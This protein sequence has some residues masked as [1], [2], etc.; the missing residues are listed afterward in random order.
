MGL[1]IP[2]ESSLELDFVYLLETD[3]RVTFFQAQPVR[4]DLWIDG[5]LRHHFPDFLIET[6]CFRTLAE[7]KPEKRASQDAYI[8]CFEASADKLQ[9]ED[10]Q[11]RVF[12]EEWICREPALT[13]AQLICR[14]ASD[15]IDPAHEL[16]IMKKV[17]IEGTP[18]A[19][20]TGGDRDLHGAVFG[21]CRLGRLAID[22]DTDEIG[23]TTKL[24][25]LQVVQ[26]LTDFGQRY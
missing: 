7:V 8:A 25:P 5:E 9:A 18:V 16:E 23:E 22:R 19:E 6:K 3:P 14:F 17:R 26:P 21:L 4:L 12:T 11:Y 10:K 20:V 24:Y 15:V 13:N 1:R 2:L